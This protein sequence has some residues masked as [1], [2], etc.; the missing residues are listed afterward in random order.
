MEPSEQTGGIAE[1]TE[2]LLTSREEFSS[3]SFCRGI[4]KNTL[5]ARQPSPDLQ[6][7]PD[8]GSAT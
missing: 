5:R 3:F 6:L 7:S 2:G 4:A 8:S 1:E